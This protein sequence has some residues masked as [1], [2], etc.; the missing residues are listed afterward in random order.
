MN[1]K[2][3]TTAALAALTSAS[4][5]LNARADITTGLVGYWNFDEG[6][7]TTVNDTSGTSPANTGTLTGTPAWTTNGWF[8][9]ALLFNPA[10]TVDAVVIPNS[11][12]MNFDSASGGTLAFTL[13]AWVNISSGSQISGAALFNKGYGGKEQYE[14]DL[15]TGAEFRFYVRNTAGTASTSVVGSANTY[16]TNAWQHVAVTYNTT[17]MY[18]YVNGALV[19]SHASLATGL[20]TTTSNVYIGN[21][22][23][24]AA[25]GLN[26]QFHGMIDDARIYNRALLA[27][28]IYQLY[29]NN[30]PAPVITEQPQSV[31]ALVGQ[32]ATFW[33]N[34]GLAGLP[35]TYQWYTNN[36]PIAGATSSVYTTPQ[37]T[38]TPY[39]GL[40]YTVVATSVASLS[41]TS[42][43]ANLT[44]SSTTPPT[45]FSAT[46]SAASAYNVV[47]VYSEPVSATALNTANYSLSGLGAPASVAAGSQANQVVLTMA[48]AL[49][50]T[51]AYTLTIQNVQDLSGNTIANTTVTV[52][53]ANLAL[54]LRADAGVLT[55]A[56]GNVSQWLDQSPN[57]NN[58]MAAASPHRPAFLAS[59]INGEPALSFSAASL[60]FLTNAPSSSLAI[61]GDISIF[62]LANMA[63]AS[64]SRTLVA[65]AKVN[66]PAPYD[67]YYGASKVTFL[68]GNGTVNGSLNSS[69]LPSAGVA[70]LF[71][72]VMAGT[73]VT[74]YTDA[75]TNGIGT[76]STTIADAGTPLYIGARDDFGTIMNGT[77]A[78]IMIF[79][80]ALSGMDL[81]NVNTYLGT[82]YLPLTITTQPHGVSC[83]VNETVLLA[84]AVNPA[85]LQPVTYQWYLNGGALTADAHGGTTANLTI[86]PAAAGDAGTYTVVISNP[87]GSVTSSNAVVAVNTLPAPNTTSGLVGW[88]KFDDASGSSTAADSSGNNNSGTLAGFA[89]T[90][91]TTMWTSG[92]INGALAFD[93]D[94]SGSNV[95]A[96]PSVGTL[97]PS[98][99][100]FSANGASGTPAFTL[101]AWVKGSA[102][103][104]NGAG[105][106]A[107]GS[108]NGGEQYTLDIYGGHY[109]FYVRDTNGV[110]FTAQTTLAPN[111]F[112]QHVAA[113]FNAID[114]TMKCYTNGALAAQVIPSFSLHTNNSPMNIG[115]RQPGTNVLAYGNAFNG[116][117][118][119]VRVYNRDLTSADVYA[120]Y[121]AA[122]FPA[123][124]STS[125][126]APALYVGSAP[127]T[128]SVTA[129]GA[130]PLYYLWYTN[131]VAAA[132]NASGSYILPG[133]AS[134]QPGTYTNYCIVTNV[135]G[136]ATTAVW[137]ITFVAQPTDNYG[138]TVFNNNG[139][140]TAWWRLS[141][142][143]NNQANGNPGAIAYDYIGGHNCVYT[144]TLLAQPGYSPV[145]QPNTAALFGVFA[146]SNSYAGEIDGSSYGLPNVNFAVPTNHNA[147]FSVEAWVK[148]TN[149]VPSSAGI[150]AKGYGSGGE[151]FDLDI[152]PQFRFFFR[153]ASGATHGPT[154]S[155]IPIVGQW[156]HVV[157]VADT[158]NGVVRLYV[159]GVDVVD[160]TGITN[161]GVGVLTATAGSL[162]GDNRVSIGSRTSSKT[163]TAYDLQFPGDIADVALYPYA[164]SATQVGLDY[165][166]SSVPPAITSSMPP[167]IPTNLFT[168]YVGDS[169][170]FSLT[171][172][173]APTLS[174]HWYT[175]GVLVSGA[176]G[177]SDAFTDLPAGRLTNSCIVS[178]LAGAATNTWILNVLA[179]PAN[180]YPQAVL[181]LNPVGYWRLN[182]PDNGLNNGNAGAACIDSVGGHDGVYNNVQLG[183]TPSYSTATDPNETAAQFGVFATANSYVSGIEG[184]SFAA[185]NGT[186]AN[187]SIV[188]WVNPTV[189]PG[190]ATTMI[191][192][193]AYGSDDTMVLDFTASGATPYRYRWYIR[194]ANGQVENAVSTITPDGNWHL[195]A[196]VCDE[197]DGAL[198]LYL[199]G[200][201]AVSTGITPG[202]GLRAPANPAV[203][204]GSGTSVSPYTSYNQQYKGQMSDVAI[205]NYALTSTQ[206]AGLFNASGQAP[207]FSLLSST[208]IGAG[209]TL[210]VTATVTIG[211]PPLSFIWYD[212]NATSVMPAQTNATLVVTN[213]QASDTY[214]L[215]VSNAYGAPQS[216][217]SV[218]VVP[219]CPQ[220]AP[221]GD[222][223]PINTSV[224]A[225]TPVPYSVAAYGSQPLYYQW[226]NGA[227]PISGATNSTYT[228]TTTVG[229]TTYSC[230]ISNSYSG[231]CAISSSPATL[232]G[233][234][235]PTSLYA[236]TVLT[237]NTPPIAYWR[238]DEPDD[239]NND[240]NY[241][242]TAYDYVGQHN[243]V[244]YGV[245][246]SQ[247]GY[248]PTDPDTAALFGV[249]ATANSYAGENGNSANTTTNIDFSAAAIG[250]NAEFSVEAWVKTTNSQSS[251]A[252]IVAKGWSG[253]G[254]QF[255]LDCTSGE[256]CFHFRLNDDE[257]VTCQSAV[258]VND[259]LWHH[260]VGVCDQEGTLAYL[261]VDGVDSVQADVQAGKGVM[262]PA[263][264]TD[265]AAD[266]VSI[267]ARAASRTATTLADQFVGTIDEVA[268]YNYPL[269]AAQV[270]AHYTAGTT[271][272]T[273]TISAVPSGTNLVVTY[274]GTLLSS[275]NVTGPYSNVTDAT[276]S[277][278]TVPATNAQMYF[279]SSAP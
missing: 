30:A 214:Y 64:M 261:Y 90:T 160:T 128:Y 49:S 259:G 202:T 111:G 4:L 139:P 57:A 2:S 141:E 211:T 84:V 8:N 73:A 43:V 58:A 250:G 212:A 61:A 226:F 69:T 38:V 137:T 7:G 279:R 52:F 74:N 91:F 134:A 218:T 59:S 114:G 88:W 22:W 181:A 180:P 277:P 133:A 203:I 44:V 227:A 86:S 198:N 127:P 257:I 153:D 17:T 81:T 207:I 34:A 252:A 32:T 72:V 48:S 70:H 42:T 119:D 107:A 46:K 26:S 176:T 164:L 113:V 126:N 63:D 150:V 210:T 124:L 53:P 190:G 271:V 253:G 118:D 85:S 231:G 266:L 224:Y 101:S 174:Y 103:Q 104:T 179:A 1:S 248:N 168:V 65:K 100:D 223:S 243:A 187:F 275:T 260:L 95:V 225:G 136:S 145:L 82:K 167:L 98:V 79:S 45:V 154:S 245:E 175:N 171:A 254:E 157:G 120:L 147:E 172:S 188:A 96:V 33:V 75:N 39:N 247:P 215:T 9:D 78:E 36:T 16:N 269:T 249:F 236:L 256:F 125:S 12:S 177:T 5:L 204:I 209:A 165:A 246:L 115:N 92:Q 142:Q 94:G 15:Y 13:A 14:L 89:D 194:N 213:I 158:Q 54:W 144:N 71:G 66:Q 116:S 169:A 152:A 205:Y 97:A 161:N 51:T 11:A 47:V 166:A 230:T 191:T 122:A 23:S 151:Q 140:I 235:L 272:V 278:Y 41:T 163:V 263:S 265:P 106:I 221:G 237:S 135:L 233:V 110:V 276:S 143:A 268:L 24:G 62:V 255:I 40:Q 109:R 132:S 29:T 148:A 31:T 200:Q 138:S 83:Y 99:L 262:E 208:N 251:G 55:D 228:A 18:L 108:G 102:T 178:N 50:S 232:V 121:A 274:T 60:Q 264:A 184:I 185:P 149:P 258:L 10:D 93:G 170:S 229:T 267:G 239:R 195:L 3:F 196:G 216:Y 219:G 197:T 28:D 162:P 220:F 80:Q 242:A 273:P 27:T 201:L 130:A 244:Y 159:N 186:S 270:L 155:I 77:I 222:I 87:L 217:V 6:S 146:S 123:I 199:D 76:I 156:Y 68:R 238:L 183:L 20:F 56:G 19:S 193:G 67:Y 35:V 112:F 241:G 21:R 206:V 173:G 25:T 182:E 131:G 189:N 117:L 129:Q 105:V 37:L 192:Q 234:P 240:G